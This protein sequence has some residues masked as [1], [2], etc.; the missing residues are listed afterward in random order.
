MISL[1]TSLETSLQHYRNTA[2]TLFA[3]RPTLSSVVDSLVQAALDQQA[4]DLR[5]QGQRIQAETLWLGEREPASRYRYSGLSEVLL[6]RFSEGWSPR[7]D[8]PDSIL[9]SRAPGSPVE[10]A[11][12]TVDLKRLGA[13]LDDW[14]DA[15]LE[16]FKAQLVAFWNEPV[17]G[18]AG[19]VPGSDAWVPGWDRHAP[20]IPSRCA[21]LSN[22]LFVSMYGTG[23][24]PNSQALQASQRLPKALVSEDQSIRDSLLG[25]NALAAYLLHAKGRRQRL[26]VTPV[27]VVFARQL[28]ASE[29]AYFLLRP[30]HDVKRLQ[31]VDE[32]WT[33]LRGQVPDPGKVDLI[34]SQLNVFDNLAGA[35]LENQL[36]AL[37]RLPRGVTQGA[38]ES[39]SA[40]VERITDPGDWFATP[41]PA[42]LTPLQRR[43]REVAPLWLLNAGEADRRGY[44]GLLSTLV[45][46]LGKSSS[47]SIFDE[48]ASLSRFSRQALR[49]AMARRHPRMPEIRMQDIQLTL[50]KYRR[51][52]LLPDVLGEFEEVQLTLPELA[53][54][55]LDDFRFGATRMRV[56]LAADVPLPDWMTA[57]Y[58]LELIAEVDIG[59]GYPAYLR[60]RLLD[61]TRYAVFR[62]QRF[63]HQ[64]QAQLPLAALELKLRGEQGMTEMGYR[65]VR[66]M[67]AFDARDRQVDGLP[68]VLRPLA[69]LASPRASPD[70]AAGMF[71]I[72]PRDT[73]RGPHLLY[74][75]LFDPPLGEY[76]S[77]PALLEAVGQSGALQDSVLAWLPAN[78]RAVYANGG[79]RQ[80]H[81]GS[82]LPGDEAAPLP[83]PAAPATLG[84]EEVAEDYVHHLFHAC[85]NAVIRQ[86][87]MQLWSNA[88]KR[89][90]RLKDSGWQLFSSMLMFASGPLTQA[91]WLILLYRGIRQDLPALQGDDE[92]A[93]AQG[94]ADMLSN[95]AAVL[96]HEVTADEREPLPESFTTPESADQRE[97]LAIEGEVS[98]ERITAPP[99]SDDSPP[100]PFDLSWSNPRQAL[101]MASRKALEK[102]S[103]RGFDTPPRLDGLGSVSASGPNKGLVHLGGPGDTGWHALIENALYQ[104]AWS[105]DGPRVVDAS[106]V[107][108]P[109]LERDEQ[110]RW[111]FDLR[112]RLR[113]GSGRET[114]QAR[115]QRKL[116]DRVSALHEQMTQASARIGTLLNDAEILRKR[117]ETMSEGKTAKNFSDRQRSDKRRE[118]LGKLEGLQVALEEKIRLIKAFNDNRQVVP[119]SATLVA[120]LADSVRNCRTL[121][122][123]SLA[124]GREGSL[125]AR[126]INEM[127]AADSDARYAQVVA[128]LKNNVEITDK[129]ILWSTREYAALDELRALPELGPAQA[130]ALQQAPVQPFTPL[131]WQAVQ[132]STLLALTLDELPLQIT[133]QMDDQIFAAIKHSAEQT[134]Y[135]TNTINRLSAE[136]PRQD[137]IDALLTA[138]NRYDETHDLL[139]YLQGLM[140]QQRLLE[141]ATRLSRLLAQLREGALNRL[142]EL[143]EEAAPAE[144]DPVPRPAPVAGGTRKKFIRTRN[145]EVFVGR[146]CERTPEQEDEIV[147]ITDPNGALVSAFKENKEDARDTFWEE[148]KA[149]PAPPI[150]RKVGL[151]R[152]VTQGQAE[153]E[154]VEALIRQVMALTGTSKDPR[155]LQGILELKAQK[156]NALADDIQQALTESGGTSAPMKTAQTLKDSLRREAA[157]LIAEGRQARITAIKRNPPR[158]A[159]LQYL[160][161]QDQVDIHRAGGRQAQE[162]GGFLQEYVV[163]HKD[164]RPLWYAHF[165]YPA[166]TTADAGFVSAHL[167][168]LAQRRL[169]SK[170]QA[171]ARHRAATRIEAGQGG[172]AQLTLDIHRGQILDKPVAQALFFNTGEVD[173]A[174]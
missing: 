110:G 150:P 144:P 138:V 6:R 38:G 124:V 7:Y 174:T 67:L 5:V 8:A 98:L 139:N 54:E 130:A 16:V 34:P 95:L 50:E 170:A 68:I 47:H 10:V 128:N 35:L 148:V 69:F 41:A 11:V 90:A 49:A 158:L 105:D 30:G 147:E 72:E 169:G 88:E 99:T 102:F 87:D 51:K 159:R 70:K 73:R 101:S 40:R 172:R 108:G 165:H 39:W 122:N 136:D 79:F 112:L 91:S 154:G 166:A 59:A 76:V 140:P 146:V 62:Q 164:G 149:E 126:E 86:A 26:G 19:K 37:E 28:S 125:S 163:S 103:V 42:P 141:Y 12:T 157:G 20:E 171:T 56:R 133:L 173:R 77:R 114:V 84:G 119:K 33:L 48:V 113:G 64:I 9:V 156:L 66:A 29:F 3:A 100:L 18:W 4:P 14:G 89:W 116:R 92:D 127:I 162:Q 104:V 160:K 75:P 65:L 143:W 109:F 24:M 155:D 71:L 81:L 83:A 36:R 1:P 118:Y 145:R 152:L 43:V 21:A 135:V 94:W 151:S 44:A 31:P 111:R 97:P 129:Q 142:F 107:P 60:Q 131:D 123:L 55:N 61:D 53:L 22:L 167:K 137:R 80:P 2:R 52:P 58:L 46:A 96:L 132:L 82:V 27:A 117:L 32:L 63:F 106:G 85:I 25:K 161:E 78:R 74:R 134:R 168:T 15:L 13:T 93:R 120:A 115:L 153:R 17:P 121:L 57:D 45:A 23:S